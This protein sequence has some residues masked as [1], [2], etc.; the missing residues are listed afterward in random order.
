M[1]RASSSPRDG[2]SEFSSSDSEGIIRSFWFDGE[3]EG[4]GGIDTDAKSYESDMTEADVAPGADEKS[5]YYG[6]RRTR[7][8]STSSFGMGSLRT[9]WM[10]SFES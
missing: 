1:S 3:D 9:S 5:P 4:H 10:T 8:G 6:K 7:N 2:S